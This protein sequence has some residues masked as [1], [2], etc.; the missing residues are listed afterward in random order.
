MDPLLNTCRYGY[1]KKVLLYSKTYPWQQSSSYSS[2]EA[3][4][5]RM[6]KSDA[7]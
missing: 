7:L 2:V 6:Q 5:T 1:I 3:D 4:G